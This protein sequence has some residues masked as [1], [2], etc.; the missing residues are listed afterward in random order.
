MSM[1]KNHA[2]LLY[3]AGD[4]RF[5]EIPVPS[6]EDNP[7]DVLIRIAY[8]GV[9]GSD[10][11]FW[12][13]GGINEMVRPGCPV[14]LGHEASGVVEV[15][16]SAVTKVK[17]GDRV[18]IEPGFPCRHC[19]FCL[20]GK[21]NLCPDMT[22]AA[23]PGP[24][25]VVHGTLATFFRLPGD[26][27]YKLPDDMGLD[28]GVIFEPLA[29][30]VHGL[31]LAKLKPGQDALVLGSGPV[32]LLSCAVAREFGAGRIFVVDI[33][34]ERLLFAQKELGVSTYKFDVTKSVEENAAALA[35]E[36]HLQEGADVI[37]EATGV[38]SCVQMGV[39][40]IKR[41][42]SYVQV[43]LGKKM[44]DFPLVV[45][46]EKEI[47]VKGCFRYGPGDFELASNLVSRGRIPL[48]SFISKIFPFHRAPDAWEAARKGEGVKILIQVD[49]SQT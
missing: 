43:G 38:E 2:C 29:V 5:E 15:V 27:C 48:K 42:G 46:S 41:G 33:N 11:H 44:V 13:H 21:Y 3:G 47:T 26:L 23:S 24:G 10:V 32:G 30:A 12:T 36:K 20:A 16:G 7:R 34:K 1:E 37:V 25:A 40:A 49:G 45:M 4:A 8:T 31:R 6:I 39:E 35:A 28:E 17:V 14:T 9:C 19:S 18:A 22:F